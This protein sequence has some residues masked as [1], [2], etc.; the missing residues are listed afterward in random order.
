MSRAISPTSSTAPAQTSA[1]TR[2]IAAAQPAYQAYLLLH[3]GF[4][5]LPIVAGLD[6]FLHLLV[7]WDEYL[8]PLATQIIPIPD[9][10]FMLV[11]GVVEIAAG[12]LVAMRPRI[13]AYVV[14]FWLWGIILNL[15]L[16]PGYYDVALRDFGLSLGALA[17]A[18]LSQQYQPKLWGV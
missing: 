15:L 8:A 7:N 12:L 6:K 2:T 5:V 16:I 11:V 14:A 13:G 9:H 4:A 1:D 18:R 17:L 10:T 3:V